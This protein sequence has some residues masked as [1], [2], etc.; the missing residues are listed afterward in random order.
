MTITSVENIHRN[1]LLDAAPHRDGPFQQPQLWNVAEPPFQ[2]FRELPTEG[3]RQTSNKTTVIID[4]GANLH[5][6]VVIMP[7]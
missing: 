4:N 6:L 5:T 7:C 1:R 2:G 3:Y